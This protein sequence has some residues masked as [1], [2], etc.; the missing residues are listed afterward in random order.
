MPEGIAQVTLIV[1]VK[2]PTGLAEITVVSDWPGA[3]DKLVGLAAKLK[4][5]WV[6][7]VTETAGDV[8]V[9]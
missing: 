1:P 3:T 5:A 2:P 9:A 6:V 8:E 4:S 7:T